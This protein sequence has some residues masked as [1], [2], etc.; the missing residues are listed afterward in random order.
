[1]GCEGANIADTVPHADLTESDPYFDNAL[2]SYQCFVTGEDSA[3]LSARESSIMLTQASMGRDGPGWS[4]F[5]W[6][7]KSRRGLYT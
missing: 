2:S 3:R 1:L 4:H 6:H 5:L 7:L